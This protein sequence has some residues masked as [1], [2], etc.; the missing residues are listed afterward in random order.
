M[1]VTSLS[2][3]FRGTLAELHAFLDRAVVD[4]GELSISLNIERTSLG[5]PE[6]PSRIDRTSLGGDYGV[7]QV[8]RTLSLRNSL[9]IARETYCQ[10][11]PLAAIRVIREAFSP[12]IGLKEAHDVVRSRR[13]MC[14]DTE[15]ETPLTPF[16]PPANT[17]DVERVGDLW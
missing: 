7:D 15:D 2:L 9:Q 13:F 17:Q 6:V 5:V 16:A 12:C 1:K 10:S 3:D 4:D 14:T 11:G 8:F